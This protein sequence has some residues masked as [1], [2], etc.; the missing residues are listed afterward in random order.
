MVSSIFPLPL[1]GEF[2]DDGRRLTLDTSF[3]YDDKEK[4]ILVVVPA[5]FQTDFNSVPRPLWGYFPPW[6]YPEAGVVHD[7]LYKYPD[8]YSLPKLK[9]PPFSPPA[10]SRQ[11]VDDIHR[12]ILDLKGCRW[13]KRQVAYAALR[14]GGWKP[15]NRY[16]EGSNS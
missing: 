2:S 5:G 11:Q 6:Q 3:V 10:L 4:G 14:V 1:N 12:R 13:T 8:R 7:W 16:R 9:A 15:W